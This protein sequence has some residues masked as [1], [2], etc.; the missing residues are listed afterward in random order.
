MV[1][2]RTHFPGIPINKH[3]NTL[4]ILKNNSPF[5]SNIFSMKSFKLNVLPTI[6][7]SDP[8]IPLKF[9]SNELNPNYNNAA[10]EG[11]SHSVVFSLESIT[12]GC[13]EDN[14]ENVN[15]NTNPTKANFNKENCS[16]NIPTTPATGIEE[17]KQIYRE[18]TENA[19]LAT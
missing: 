8:A 11:N 6:T 12:N 1:P 2:C 19:V 7:F 13:L 10:S 4:K 18:I 5:A 15:S 14:S 17:T 16:V 9:L 3:T